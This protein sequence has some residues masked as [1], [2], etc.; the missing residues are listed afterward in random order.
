MLDLPYAGCPDGGPGCGKTYTGLFATSVAK[1]SQGGP[2]GSRWSDLLGLPP[3][4]E[5]GTG[6]G[7]DLCW[8]CGHCETNPERRTARVWA[9][10][11]RQRA[12]DRD[13]LLDGDVLPDQGRPYSR[14]RTLR[15][16][17]YAVHFGAWTER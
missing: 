16:L 12:P 3:D 8:E 17:P 2:R 9:F 11:H 5:D 1:V 7:S 13:A 15:E 4:R 10:R 6:N 14:C